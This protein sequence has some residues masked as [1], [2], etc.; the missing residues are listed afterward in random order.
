MTTMKDVYFRQASRGLF[1]RFTCVDCGKTTE[2][3]E[4]KLWGFQ[5]VGATGKYDLAKV[6][7]QALEG[8]LFALDRNVG[9][10]KKGIA[11]GNCFRPGFF[12]VPAYDLED[13]CPFC[14]KKQPNKGAK[15]EY[16]WA[17]EVEISD[18][19]NVVIETLD[20]PMQ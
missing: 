4:Y 20:L 17:D 13:K 2:W 16:K 12:G 3:M 1:Y 9:I 7:E 19:D 11:K 10:A 8:A 5:R 6:I 15:I 14:G 18:T